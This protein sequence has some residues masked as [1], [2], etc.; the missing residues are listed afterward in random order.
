MIENHVK[1]LATVAKES[2]NVALDAL[3]GISVTDKTCLGIRGYDIFT[4]GRIRNIIKNIDGALKNSPTE[5]P[6]EE[7]HG[8]L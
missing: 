5:K 4:E 3:G 2:L 8:S 6:L 7:D 1:V